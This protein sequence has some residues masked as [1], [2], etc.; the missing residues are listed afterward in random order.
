MPAPLVYEPWK[1]T[2]EQQSKYGCIIGKDYPSPQKTRGFDR[3]GGGGGP[4]RG[5]RP[6]GKPQGRQGGGNGRDNQRK[7][8]SYMSKKKSNFEMY[9]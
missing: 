2:A 5:R 4:G 7:I 6:S 9:G 8:S 1:M 3:P